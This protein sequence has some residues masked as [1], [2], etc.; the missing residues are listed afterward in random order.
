MYTKAIQWAFY[1]ITIIW[2]H[3]F[4]LT[5]TFHAA[6]LLQN[7]VR[8]FAAIFIFSIVYF[9]AD[10]HF[11]DCCCSCLCCCCCSGKSMV[12]I[13][14]FFFFLLS[15]VKAGLKSKQ[16]NYFA[17]TLLS[18]STC[19]D[20]IIAFNIPTT[21]KRFQMVC[22]FV[23]VLFPSFLSYFRGLLVHE[24]THEQPKIS[25]V[26]SYACMYKLMHNYNIPCY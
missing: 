2:Q 24:M 19:S 11:L 26:E 5:Y 23:F 15:S 14:T 9:M 4:L 13:A 21:P 18:S 8:W 20:K 22:F 10:F 16:T 25:S 17:L 6:Y 12:A 3:T 7:I 1:A